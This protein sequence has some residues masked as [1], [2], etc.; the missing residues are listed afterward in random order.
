MLVQDG[1]FVRAGTKLSDGATSPFD[2][3]NIMGPYAVQ[4]YLV[5]G[6]QEV[7]RSQGIKINDKHIE[8]ISRQMMRRVE[9][10]DPGDTSFLEGEAVERYDFLEANDV[11]FDKKVVEDSGESS[12]LKPG[13]LITIRELR[14]ENSYLKRNDK[15][16]VTVRPAVAATSKP[17][18]QGITKSSLGV[19]SWISAASFQETTK[20]LSTAAIGAKRDDLEGLKENVISGKKIP[21]GTG[22]KE[23]RDLLVT[24]AKPKYEENVGAETVVEAE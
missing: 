19:R 21:A 16:L 22:T 3:L 10:E 20:V 2:I 14:E 9:I 23:F 12:K 15:K 13:Q 8:V 17:L 18:L 6:I 4:Q 7:Y 5:N 1:D 24:V 11:I